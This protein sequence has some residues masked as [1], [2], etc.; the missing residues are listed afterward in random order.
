[1]LDF[2]WLFRR[3]TTS[4]TSRQPSAALR[5]ERLE[6]RLTPALPS[7]WTSPPAPPPGPNEIW[8]ATADELTAAVQNLQ[9]N[10]T[11][12]LRA[13]EYRL[14]Q[15]LYVGKASPLQNVAIRGATGDFNDVVL[16][17]AGMDDPSVRYGFSVY[18]A[19]DV[20]IADL[21]VGEV[22][23]SG[24]DLQGVQGAERVKIQHCRVFDTGEQQIKANAGGGGVDDCVVE[25]CLIEYTDGP[26]TVDHGGG[27]G[28]TNGV[29]AHQADRWVIRDCVFRNFHTP[30][31]SDHEFA[32]AVLMWNYSTGTVVEGNTFLDCDR[33]VA[34]GLIDRDGFD[35]QGGAIRNN[36][37]YQ[38]P[39]LFSAGRRARSDG[40]LLVY[41][42][43]GT[44]VDH[45]TVLTNGNSRLSV[46]VRWAA[47]GVAFRH[48]LA[49][50][51]LGARDGGVYLAAD[52]RLSATPEMFVDPAAGDLRLKDTAAT[53]A[54]AIDQ[55]APL[56]GTARDFER[57]ARP[58]GT[59]ADIGADEFS[60]VAANRAPEIVAVT[61]AR[62]SA[63][64]ATLAALAADDATGLTFTW[65]VLTAPTGG[66]ATFSANRTALAADTVATFTK[67]G[68][69]T[70]RVKV[71]DAGGLTAR[72][73]VSLR[74]EQV[75]TTLTVA[76][77]TVTLAPGATKQFAA[78]ARDQFGRRLAVPPTLSWSVTGGGSV[79]T[80]GRYTAPLEVGTAVV[81]AA[82][83]SMTATADV[84]ILAAA[85]F[86]ARR[87]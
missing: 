81:Q 6:D 46:E 10:Q 79:T 68:N 15:P 40:Q 56:S 63:T 30:D 5:C 57:Q 50:A 32:P 3:L 18:N 33:A 11:I 25:A 84:T 71:T 49:D 19:Q 47:Q 58:A 86:V 24:I 26:P 72:R 7:S 59:L 75:L 45:N 42:S 55:V 67:A 8:V 61:V 53:R 87:S 13:G 66:G 35:H 51:P 44:K 78:V 37:V 69:Y 12:V 65:K 39:G 34:L 82:S 4:Q 20:V 29:D 23:Y 31:G 52:N 74:V 21:S 62:E 43:P 36:F 28:Y 16:R 2:G 14:T 70:L 1:M 17:G 54:V 27:T 41:D 77:T 60:T 38:S 80:T 83:G 76:P 48:N 64:T 22:Y 85:G 9:S 73:L